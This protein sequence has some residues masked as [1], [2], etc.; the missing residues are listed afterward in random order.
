M[1]L[2]VPVLW[3]DNSP[4]GLKIETRSLPLPGPTQLGGHGMACRT[5]AGGRR[6]NNGAGQGWGGRRLY[7]AS[8]CL[9]YC[10][11]MSYCR[12]GS[13]GRLDRES[14]V[15]FIHYSSLITQHHHPIPGLVVI[16][17]CVCQSVTP[18]AFLRVCKGIKS[19]HTRAYATGPVATAC[20]FFTVL[21]RA[22]IFYAA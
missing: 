21:T 6:R 7:W 19:R 3:R 17:E 15:I 13:L 2:D 14:V 4:G 1:G 22:V 18:R 16:L 9:L 10:C 8:F 5:E 12:N 20:L 11:F